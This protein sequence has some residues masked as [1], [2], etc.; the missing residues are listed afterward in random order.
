MSKGRTEEKKKNEEVGE[1]QGKNVDLYGSCVCVCVWRES[2]FKRDER[3]REREREERRR[4]KRLTW[5]RGWHVCDN[6]VDICHATL[7]FS[8]T[9]SRIKLKEIKNM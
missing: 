5:R 6:M 9:V 1:T 3:E 7:A 4:R 2:F 8:V